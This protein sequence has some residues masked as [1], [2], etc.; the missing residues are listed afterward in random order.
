MKKWAAAVGMVLVLGA[1]Q[2]VAQETYPLH[3]DPLDGIWQGYAGEWRHVS[4][5]LVALA[6]ATP[7]EKFA[8]RPAPGVRSTS[9]VY[10]H[11]VMANFYLLSVC[12]PPMP[13]DLK[14]DAEKSVTSKPEVIAWLKRSLEAVMKAHLGETPSHLRQ[15]VKVEGRDSTVDAMYLRIIIHANEHMGQLVAYAR[16]SGIVPPWSK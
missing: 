1:A 2:M 12:G 4:N 7:A 13:P 8:W 9:E 3:P 14:E 11:I 10:M 5:Q 16:M 15:K 6:E